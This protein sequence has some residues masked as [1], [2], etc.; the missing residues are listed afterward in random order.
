MKL[1]SFLIT[2]AALTSLVTGAALASHWEPL[3]PSN[4]QIVVIRYDPT[5]PNIAYAGTDEALFKTVNGGSSW[6]RAHSGA[7]AGRVGAIAIDPITPT[8]LWMA[9]DD[10]VYR[11]TNGGETW[12]NASFGLA[13]GT[14][15]DLA[16]HAESPSTL[17]AG[18]TG[19]YRTTNAGQSWV[20]S[21]LV[22]ETV[23]GLTFDLA[24]PSLAYAAV[25]LDGTYRSTDS[26]L[27]WAP[28]GTCS[29]SAPRDLASVPSMPGWVYLGANS[30]Y[31]STDAAISWEVIDGDG[32]CVAADLPGGADDPLVYFGGS[33]LQRSVDGGETF[34]DDTPVLSPAYASEPE[35]FATID[36]APGNRVLS[37]IDGGRIFRR[38]ALG[39]WSYA[40]RGIY[41]GQVDAVA[42]RGTILLAAT[43]SGI[44][45]SSS[46]GYDWDKG[47]EDDAGDYFPLEVPFAAVALD[48]DETR[49]YGAAVDGGI[50]RASGDL[51]IWTRVDGTQ[52]DATSLATDPEITG[53]VYA[54]YLRSPVFGGVEVSQD[55][56]DTWTDHTFLNID[57]LSVHAPSGGTGLAYAG[58][59]DGVYRTTD[60]GSSWASLSLM[61]SAIQSLASVPSDPARLFAA[62]STGVLRSTNA[63]VSWEA[64]STGLPS[65]DVRDLEVGELSS[66]FV[67]AGLGTGVYRRPIDGSESWALY[68]V[69]DQPLSVDI[70]G[71]ASAGS[72]VFAATSQGIW[73][74]AVSATDV[75]AD[76]TEIGS[77]LRVTAWPN[78]S[79]RSVHLSWSRELSWS[80]EGEDDGRL[81]IIDPS[82]R[83]VREIQVSAPVSGRGTAIWDGRR[84]DGDRVP[85]GIYWYQLVIGGR[86]ASGTVVRLR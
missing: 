24:M 68:S 57:V 15:T 28:G 43:A 17:L 20:A 74:A 9:I 73:A 30:G 58:T 59:S 71:L 5:D 27:T 48:V 64:W 19:I 18:G 77:T 23:L 44:H 7:L 3:G 72:R 60:S 32:R 78:P 45:V 55:G 10:D 75:P 35:P 36:L 70:H 4:G 39:T 14:I 26:G 80:S 63:G 85:P 65:T 66:E 37:G 42:A 6:T 67:F 82:G 12:T 2:T 62:A 11:S 38:S 47:W 41:Q 79:N 13:A 29:C 54:G 46:H 22:G 40:D 1:N 53:L 8:R 83:T 25:L 50:Y 21:G 69:G 84:E 56:G 49:G 86:V 61:G 16:V 34:I 51:R 81:R 76:P 31:R 52:G 33:S